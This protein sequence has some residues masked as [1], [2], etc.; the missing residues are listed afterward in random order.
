MIHMIQQHP[1]DDQDK[2]IIAFQKIWT[3]LIGAVQDT[4]LVTHDDHG[5]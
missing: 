2:F 5:Q 4:A 3:N 1:D